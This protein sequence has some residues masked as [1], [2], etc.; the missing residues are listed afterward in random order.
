MNIVFDTCVLVDILQKREP[1][2]EDAAELLYA[3]SDQTINGI[4]TAKA[5][6]DIYYLMR[7][8]LSEK[9]VRKVISTIA[10]LFD[11]I[12][13]AGADCRLALLSDMKDYE[14][15]IMVETAKRINADGI[16]TRNLKDYQTEEVKIYAPDVLRKIVSEFS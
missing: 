15:A 16:V 4:I 6:T 11:I 9:E 13:T 1:F 5:L 14:D 10:E 12:D 7:K 3:V 2:Y 8:D